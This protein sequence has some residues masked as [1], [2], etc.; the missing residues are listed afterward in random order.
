MFSWGQH[1]TL[2]SRK[3]GCLEKE[4]AAAGFEPTT[5]Q[6]ASTPSYTLYALYSNFALCSPIEGAAR[7]S[8]TFMQNAF[9]LCLDPLLANH[10]MPERKKIIRTTLESNPRH[11]G[12]KLRWR[13]LDP[14]RHGL[15][16]TTLYVTSNFGQCLRK[17][18]PNQQLHEKKHQDKFFGS[19]V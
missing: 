5:S 13:P 11:L 6:P 15:S 2:V 1:F 9:L 16:G 18:R 14:L 7:I 12:I 17:E 10:L 19:L 3:A 4:M 8:C